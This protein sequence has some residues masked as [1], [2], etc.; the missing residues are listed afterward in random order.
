LTARASGIALS[1]GALLLLV[2]RCGGDDFTQGKAPG[3]DAAVD[4][5]SGDGATPGCP[6][7]S[8][9]CADN[10]VP[11]DD[12]A[13]GCGEPVCNPCP[14]LNG[15][16]F[17][18]NGCKINCDA[19]YEDCDQSA[20]NGCET[21][22]KFDPTNCGS[23][24]NGCSSGQ[25]CVDGKCISNGCPSGQVTCTVGGPCISLGTTE[26]CAHCSDTCSR[27]NTQAACNQGKCEIT[28]C[29]PGYADCDD[30]PKNGCEADLK[31]SGAHCGACKHKCDTSNAV[32]TQC[33]AGACVPNCRPTGDQYFGDCSTPAPPSQDDGCE[34]NI[35]EPASCGGCGIQCQP[36]LV[37][38]AKNAPWPRCVCTQDKQCVA[39][40]IVQPG[41]PTTCNL[42][43]GNCSCP[44][45]GQCSFG[46]VCV[47]GATQLTCDC[48]GKKCLATEHCCNGECT[49]VMKDP[50]NCG[51]CGVQCGPG[52]SCVAGS[53][54]AD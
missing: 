24:N 11:F 54:A 28:S 25:S 51:T 5:P 46:E 18:N 26:N 47:G 49:A 43:A 53:C 37:C 32:S 6:T 29:S 30:D 50:Q 19:G 13:F 7:G 2:P 22:T 36:G 33:V 14:S 38:E 4:A 27:P 16:P 23:C 40:V 10:C 41:L 34:T 48:G 45:S 52:K 17:C 42:A 8:K 44:A 15:K 12:P 20:D 35:T 3:A 9:L 31:T 21:Y 39:Q 1:L